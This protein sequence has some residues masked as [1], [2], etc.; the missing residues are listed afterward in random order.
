VTYDY[1]D[2][3]DE[4]YG[5]GETTVTLSLEGSDARDSVT[6][7]TKA[8]GGDVKL[9]FTLS[10]YATLDLLARVVMFTEVDVNEV[11]RAVTDAAQQRDAMLAGDVEPDPDHARDLVLDIDLL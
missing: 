4:R 6:F 7:V 1:A 2:W 9:A 10:P 3:D 8:L 11:I 5:E